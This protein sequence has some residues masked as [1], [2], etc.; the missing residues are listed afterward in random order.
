MHSLAGLPAADATEL[1]YRPALHNLLE[2]LAKELGGGITVLHEPKRTLY[3]A[4]DFA[5]HAAGGAVAGYVECKKPGENLPLMSQGAQLRK[6]AALSPNILLCDSYRFLLLREG[7]IFDQAS[8]PLKKAG[9]GEK[10][11]LRMVI[12]KFL[13][14]SP[15][16]IG[17]RRQLA[18]NLA[19]RC[20]WL[21]DG[22]AGILAITTPP[23]GSRPHA[24][25][26]TFCEEVFQELTPKEFAG[27]FA[28]TLI[29]G[30]LLARLN[31]P[32]KKKLTL[33][34][35]EHI[36]GSFSLIAELADFLK[37]LEKPLY[38][39]LK[40]IIDDILTVVNWMDAAAVAESLT[41]R[42]RT[43][44]ESDR[45]LYFY[46]EF[47][48]EFDPAL[49]KTRGVYYTPPE[50][51]RFIVGAA[52]RILIKDFG[53]AEGLSDSEQVTALDFAAG[54]GTFMLEMFR[55]VL[56]GKSPAMREQLLKGHILQNFHGFEFLIAPY[57][58]A[59]IKLAQFIKDNV[60]PLHESER[61]RIFITNTLEPPAISEG[62][63][64][65][66]LS[67]FL[68]A[69]SNDVKNAQN[70]KKQPVLV[71]TGNP[72][73]SV[74]S[75]NKGEWINKK[76]ADY[77]SIDGESLR[78]RKQLLT[79]D[80]VKFMRFAQWKMQ[81][82]PRG[83]IAVITNHGFLEN[84]T[85]RG[86]RKSL[87]DSFDA[88]YF[89]D[90]HGNANRE[91]TTPSG[92]KDENV[93]DIRQGVAISLLVKN[94]KTKI[95]GVFHA[96]MWG[97]RKEK[98]RV[99]GESDMDSIKWRK[100]KPVNPFYLF[101][102][103]NERVA[104]EYKKF[105]S[106]RDIFSLA[107]VGLMTR[108]DAVAIRFDESDI[109]RTVQD[110]GKMNTRDLR[111]KYGILEDSVNWEVAKVR[112]DLAENAGRILP[113]LYRPFDSRFT[114]YTGKSGGFHSRPIDGVMR[115][116]LA[117]ENIGLVTVRQ[118]KTGKTWQHCSIVRGL[119]ESTCISNK[120]SEINYLMPLY[121][122]ESEAGKNGRKKT[123]NFTKSFRDWIDAR[124]RVKFQPESIFSAI[125]A[126][127]HSPNY[128]RVYAG[129][130]RMDFPRVDFPKDAGEFRRL[131]TIGKKLIRAHLLQD[132][133]GKLAKIKG[134]SAH[135]K[136][137]NYCEKKKRLHINEN[138]FFA[139]LPPEVWEFKI[140]GYQPLKK[141]IDA[142]KGRE[143]TLPEITVI[144][145]AANAIAKTI[146]L[147]AEIDGGGEKAKAKKGKG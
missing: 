38:G 24:L 79:D 41:Y 90:L 132:G 82:V 8:L 83:V 63:M 69:L 48:A 136:R 125:Y 80:Y 60:R 61:L 40:P 81:D 21:R 73:Y 115:H 5:I 27:A 70:V 118:F 129:C 108:R 66:V 112:K 20:R 137:A 146:A 11:K 64:S 86:M 143:L 43:A 42:K 9:K 93:F 91:E 3:G 10:E 19:V 46:E 87:L 59:H 25:Y 124:Y 92:G 49:R 53:I 16:R 37:D 117:G 68:P 50:V 55:R 134:K 114:Y 97:L 147:M 113:V 51:V 116:M 99:C 121:R 144:G 13:E 4:P 58:V 62:A 15:E 75:Q 77:K 100:I 31:V 26:R 30:A 22:L 78:E 23:T 138:A 32:E 96:D 34:L 14:H 2:G 101:V 103:R 54:T 1:S 104:K 56:E 84:P 126:I 76:I 98:Y 18:K 74:A 110:F 139:P 105:H 88:L 85:F 45:W 130:L 28:Q 94:P 119:M 89:L 107:N 111:E 106:I 102:P 145:K 7:N 123:E 29:Y 141:Y 52:E 33:R 47:L 120:G 109:E 65:G 72:P 131:S 6:Y 57:A 17:D 12:R 95:R 142:R 35:E 133:A 36:P 135:V 39:D 44:D 127:L 71:I 122:Y 67:G 140:G 128:R